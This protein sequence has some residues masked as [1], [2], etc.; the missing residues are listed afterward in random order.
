MAPYGKLSINITGEKVFG[1]APFPILLS[2]NTNNSFTIQ[3]NTFSLAN[4]M[5]FISD[6]QVTWNI[7]YNMGGWLFNR[8]PYLNIL[9]LREVFGFRG[10]WG[11]LS[12]KN[13]PTHNNKLILFPTGTYTLEKRPYMEASI[14]ID[15][16][17]GFFRIDYIRRLSYPDHPHTD[18]S[19]FRL[20]FEA[21]F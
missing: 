21:S 2:P 12:E 13:D 1:E 17:F 6:Q 11:S 18:K 16:I 14:G 20:G 4:R 8:I 10:V 19:A 5:E 3:T 9:K 15:N 7:N